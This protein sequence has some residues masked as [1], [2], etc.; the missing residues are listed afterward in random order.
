MFLYPPAIFLGEL[1]MKL[2]PNFYLAEFVNSETATRLG[3]DNTPS[4]DIIKALTY[5]ATQ[6]EDVRQL[7]NNKPIKINSG[8]RCPALNE[9]VGGAKNSAHMYGWAVDFVCP[10]H[11]IPFK[12]I[13]TLLKAKLPFD[14]CINER[15]W[16]H[17]S[18]DP[19]RRK[20]VMNVLQNEQRMKFY[21][22]G[23]DGF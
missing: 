14:K 17:L 4:V 19:R 20:Q 5:T 10:G 22:M 12:I 18:F 21:R 16:V 9:A 1:S 15:T 2:S 23:Y 7:L 11:G 8:Y 3:I 6:L 13:Q